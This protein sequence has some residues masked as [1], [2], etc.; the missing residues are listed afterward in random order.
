MQY[1]L[2]TFDGLDTSCMVMCLLRQ[3]DRQTGR[4]AGRQADGQADRF[5]QQTKCLFINLQL[6]YYVDV[7]EYDF[8]P[9][10]ITIVA[11]F[12]CDND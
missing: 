10:E 3:T 5:L 9:A 1:V 7:K 4:Q 6:F 8:G 12:N 2:G 11:L